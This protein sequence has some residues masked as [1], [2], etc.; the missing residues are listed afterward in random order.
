MMHCVL[1]LCFNP[2]DEDILLSSNIVTDIDKVGC[3]RWKQEMLSRAS[4]KTTHNHV[5][6]SVWKFD[7]GE[8]LTVGSKKVLD[9]VIVGGI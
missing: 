9:K 2:E 8:F 3:L 6:A 1:D 5:S 7:N 4:G